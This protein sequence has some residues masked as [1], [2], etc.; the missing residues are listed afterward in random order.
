MRLPDRVQD[1]L[2]QEIF[3]YLAQCVVFVYKVEFRIVRAH[4]NFS[5][6]LAN[7]DLVYLDLSLLTFSL[8]L[9]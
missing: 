1:P 6:E 4:V 5:L 2:L 3:L 7:L 9:V 8:L